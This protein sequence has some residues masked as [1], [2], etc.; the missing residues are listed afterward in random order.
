[1]KYLKLFEDFDDENEED[2]EFYI[3]IDNFFNSIRKSPV[4]SIQGNTFRIRYISFSENDGNITARINGCESTVLNLEHNHF[5]N[6]DEFY[7]NVNKYDLQ[8][9]ISTYFGAKLNLNDIQ[10]KED[11]WYDFISKLKEAFPLYS[12]N[13]KKLPKCY[14][15][16][17]EYA[18]SLIG[19][20][21]Q[22]Y[23]YNSENTYIVNNVNITLNDSQGYEYDIAV[24]NI[25]SNAYGR[26]KL[27]Y[28][29]LWKLLDT[30]DCDLDTKV[31][32]IN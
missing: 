20:K 4:V 16:P 14:T 25:N 22:F 10:F 8:L 3:E 12:E 28:V 6:I 21:I 27:N 32:I 7:D 9:N 18:M 17:E 13:I 26:S 30:G 15:I 1:M 11:E 24:Q 5:K 29:E 19:K 23:K 2:N 31:K